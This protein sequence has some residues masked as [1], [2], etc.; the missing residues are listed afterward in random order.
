MYSV[1]I[2]FVNFLH[3]FLLIISGFN[4]GLLVNENLFHTDKKLIIPSFSYQ[5]ITLYEGRGPLE[6]KID[7][8][9]DKIKA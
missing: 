8:L 9:F 2:N 5:K 6:R 1:D 4:E 7:L 3:N